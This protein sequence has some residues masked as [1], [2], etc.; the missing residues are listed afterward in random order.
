MRLRELAERIGAT[1]HGNGDI[2][3]RNVSSIAPATLA[4]VVFVDDVRFLE[5]ALECGAGAV[6]ARESDLPANADTIGKPMLIHANPRLAFARAAEA[7]RRAEAVPGFVHP[8]A[9]IEQ[10]VEIAAD[11]RIEAYAVIGRDCRVGA[12]SHVG[13]GCIL[14]AGVTLGED[15]DLVA[16]VTIYA[17]AALGNRVVVHAGAVL[18]SDGFGFARDP[19]SGRYVKFPQIG[20]L[21]IE[22][23]VE[24]GAN[25]TIDR[26]ALGETVIGRGTKLDNMVHIGHNAQLGENVVIAAQS[27]VSG[28]AVLERDVLVGGQ[29]GIADHVRIEEGA[30]LGAQSGIPTKKVIRGK[31]IVFWG[32]PAR[33]IAEYLRELAVLSRLARK[34]RE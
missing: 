18:G 9:L 20:R 33:P 26:G 29:V 28:S 27:G 3:I 21:R 2:E 7:L 1:L 17:G 32:T 19:E 8:T 15:C 23:D 34:K 22:D 10:N 14:G 4:D 12:R 25:A 11:A 24:I 5:Q 16:R 30:I 6:I 31:G 13:S